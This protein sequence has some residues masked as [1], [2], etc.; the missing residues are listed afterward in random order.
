MPEAEGARLSEPML[1]GSVGVVRGNIK[2]TLIKSVACREKARPGKRGK[3]QSGTCV[4][5]VGNV[6]AVSTFLLLT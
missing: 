4:D 6:R 1:N 2:Q 5:P 3:A